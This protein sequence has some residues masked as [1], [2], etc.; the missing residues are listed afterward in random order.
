LDWKLA[1]LDKMRQFLVE[2]RLRAQLIDV[3]FRDRPYFR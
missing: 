1:A 3:R 2:H